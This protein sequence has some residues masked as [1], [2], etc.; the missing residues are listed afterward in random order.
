MVSVLLDEGCVAGLCCPAKRVSDKSTGC[1]LD[2]GVG[3]QLVVVVA[4]AFSRTKKV[5]LSRY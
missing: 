2:L 3:V 4:P 1:S 5:A